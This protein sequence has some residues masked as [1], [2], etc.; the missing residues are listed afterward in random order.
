MWPV[1]KSSPRSC[2]LAAGAEPEDV[3][4]VRGLLEQL[5]AGDG[6][7]D[8]STVR[9]GAVRARASSKSYIESL[10]SRGCT[11]SVV[12]PSWPSC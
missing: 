7:V 10:A 11:R 8:P 9:D 5:A 4:L 1:P 6:C 2:R 3:G 12:E